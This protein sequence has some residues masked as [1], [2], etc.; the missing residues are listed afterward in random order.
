MERDASLGRRSL[1]S[2]GWRLGASLAG[3]AVLSVRAVVLARLVE[4]ETF[5]VYAFAFA[6]VSLSAVV[7]EFGLGEAFLHR[8]PETD[9]EERA[10]RAHFACS[11]LLTAG[12]AA[13]MAV[14]TLR[15]A[16]PGM[17]EP[18]LVLTAA[19]AG[20]QLAR[21]PALILVRRVEQR[22]LAAIDLANSCA[23]TVVAVWLAAGGAELWSLLA[24]DVV[25]AVVTLAA[26]YAVSP[27]WTPRVAFSRTSARYFLGF[28]SRGLAASLLA[29]VLERI[30]NLW[31]G[32]ALGRTEL[33]Y[34]SRAF[35]FATYPRRFAAQPILAVVE[36]SYA[37]LK[38]DQ[39]RLQRAFL[40]VTA[41]LLRLGLLAGGLLAVVAEDFV[42]VLLG[43]R[44]LPMVPAFRVLLVLAVVAPVER[45]LAGLLVAT[46]QPGKVAVARSMQLALVVVGLLTMGQAF[47]TVGVATAVVAG[48]LVATAILWMV[49]RRLLRLAS[50]GVIVG[51]VAVTAV[52]ATVCLALVRPA[53]AGLSALS[54]LGLLAGVFTTLFVAASFL[55]DRSVF[56]RTIATLS[57]LRTVGTMVSGSPAQPRWTAGDG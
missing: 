2:A 9:D 41:V 15:F 5:G 1:S 13:L 12:W 28:G 6:V 19:R 25:T 49:A 56:R 32:M 20:L 37:E 52:T 42:T 26:L 40:E 10:A 33:G 51:P 45:S 38:R 55:I 43:P 22:R 16:P 47:G 57:S 34:Y 14:A 27:V 17:R 3:A 30:D 46:G 35:T 48:E 21:T 4:V 54:R 29:Q 24:T 36:G 53:A 18:L 50:A 8:A 39:E 11:L 7:A 31:T 44:W 23:T